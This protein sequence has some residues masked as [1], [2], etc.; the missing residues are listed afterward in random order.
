[1]TLCRKCGKEI[2]DGSELCEECQ[3]TQENFDTEYLTELIQS[4]EAEI[5]QSQGPVAEDALKESAVEDSLLDGL[6]SDDVSS[7]DFSMDD[8]SLDS[9][10]PEEEQ[11]GE[12]E[13]ELPVEESVEEE[14]LEELPVEE[15][16]EQE[17]EEELPV[18]ESLE[19]DLL[20]EMERILSETEQAEDY[21][22]EEIPLEETP[23]EEMPLEETPLEETPLEETPS[24]ESLEEPILEAVQSGEASDEA[25]AADEPGE[26][27]IDELLSMLSQDYEN[28]EETAPEEEPV[29]ETIT[30]TL[31]ESPA[32]ASL[33]SEDD[34]DDGMFAEDIDAL[35]VDD[36]FD[37]ALSAV[38]YSEAEEEAEEE[39]IE[40]FIS[41]EE[42][43]LSGGLGDALDSLGLDDG[44]QP[45]ALSGV[46]MTPVADPL[47]VDKKEKKPGLLKRIFGNIITEQT[48][49]EEAKEREQEQASAEEKAIAREEKKK[50]AAEQKA[51]KEEQTKAIKEQKAAEKAEKAAIKEANKEEKKRLKAEME[52]NEVVG[53]INPVGASIVMVFFGLICVLVILG[54]QSLSYTS[55]VR[56]A[57][58]SFDERDYRNAYE[59]LAGVEVSENSQEMKDK[60]RICMQLQR[61]LDGF[62]N[63][64][65]M[66]LY[67]EALDSLMKGIRSYD[68]NKGKA[69]DYDIL[70][71]YN[72]LE[73][74]L[75]K[76]LYDEFGVSESQARSINS[77]ETQEEY[78]SRLETIIA[79]WQRRNRE[80]EK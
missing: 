5:E 19:E 65:E 79:Q 29:E 73:A 76:Q 23:S 69:E 7:D 21:P 18:E 39:V 67:L 27:D 30:E 17:P 47:A 28:Y 62:Q 38:D 45:E 3:A 26:E 42:S 60:V 72:E 4:M 51:E 16:F 55:S 41:P 52:A 57:E 58:S 22:S 56:G 40:E 8:L 71:Q 70:G 35:S 74:K 24:E 77:T 44:E 9:I 54:T 20:E 34:Q 25:A 64:Y 37:D 2:S 75:A 33:F 63:Y 48:A 80:D 32:E 68:D 43:E 6:L 1:M 78:T 66:K 31:D 15:S 59:S 14:A 13:E 36:I 53:R 46:G 50:Q 61:G 49:E 10:L 12:S 11:S